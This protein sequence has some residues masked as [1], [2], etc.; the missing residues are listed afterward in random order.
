M[1]CFILCPQGEA[2]MKKYRGFTLIELLIVMAIIAILTAIAVPNFL[3]AQVRAKVAC[4]RSDFRSL[5]SALESFQAENNMYPRAAMIVDNSINAGPAA[6]PGA[7]PTIKYRCSFALLGSP[8]A[9]VETGATVRRF[10]LTTPVAYLAQLPPDV[11][12]ETRGVV[13]GY[14]NVA[15]RGWLVWSSG[16]AGR[17]GAGGIDHAIP[18]NR[19]GG[20]GTALDKATWMNSTVYRPWKSNPTDSLLNM[21][22]DTTNGTSSVGD[23]YVLR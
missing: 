4:V 23:I 20:R 13:Y 2:T 18:P 17:E 9:L 15:D 11:F 19:Y 16:P 21:T 22:Y 14:A 3:E 6:Q 12:A 10:T 8:E 5:S 1:H 7:T